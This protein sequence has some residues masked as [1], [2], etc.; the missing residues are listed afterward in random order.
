MWQSSI[1]TV[2]NLNRLFTTSAAQKEQP[3]VL[4]LKPGIYLS[5][6]T[7]TIINKADGQQVAPHVNKK[8]TLGAGADLAI[9]F[10]VSYNWAFEITNRFVWEHDR[11]ID[12]VLSSKQ[13][14]DDYT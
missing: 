4:L 3:L 14:Y 7:S 13:A 2:F 9:R 6:F 11:A 5:R 10:N 8:L 12:G 1:S